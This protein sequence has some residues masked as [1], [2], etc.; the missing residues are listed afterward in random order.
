M[1]LPDGA[2][3]PPV[4]GSGPPAT[5]NR[6]LLDQL[7]YAAT[8][9]PVCL[10][11]ERLSI[12]CQ[13]AVLGRFLEAFLAPFRPADRMNTTIH[14]VEVGGTWAAYQDGGRTVSAASVPAMARSL[15][16][17]LNTV[18]LAAPTSDVHVH[19]AVASLG[20]RALILPG[21]S[22]AG[23]TTLVAALALAGWTYLS[24]EVAAFGPK[25]H[26]VHPY[27]RPLALERGSWPIVADAL[28]LWP[29]DVP[30]LVTDLHL[31]LPASLGPPTPPAPAPPAAIVFPEVVAGAP[32]VL[33]PMDRADTLAR[34][35]SLTF[36]LRD[37]GREGF[38]ALAGGV[39]LSSCHR[40]VLDGV[41]AAPD[42][43]RALLDDVIGTSTE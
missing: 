29:D 16:W 34:L 7:P 23:K 25:G 40:L 22:G 30:E 13:D 28:D 4:Q 42:L 2:S 35:V 8:I 14:V 20:G 17:L 43:L 26:V 37:L 10:L 12:R 15:V 19:A 41:G 6:R 21:P 31:V 38:E 3:P 39:R 32:T 1:S 24:D 33:E 18:A 27:P 9:G 11:G 36:N 5:I